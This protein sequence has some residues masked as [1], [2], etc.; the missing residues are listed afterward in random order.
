MQ[1]NVF[2]IWDIFTIELFSSITFFAYNSIIYTTIFI[3]SFTKLYPINFYSFLMRGSILL[4]RK[5][6]LANEYLLFIVNTHIQDINISLN[7]IVSQLSLIANMSD[8]HL[9]LQRARPVVVFFYHL[10]LSFNYLLLPRLSPIIE[11]IIWR[12]LPLIDY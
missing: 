3:F 5:N 10:A 9:I 11:L 12:C 2:T 7:I 4:L 8:T 6:K 1:L